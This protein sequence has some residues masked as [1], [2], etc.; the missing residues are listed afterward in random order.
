MSKG[1]CLLSYV[2]MR[3]EP[4]SGAE[5]VS[6]LIFGES[7]LLT[8]EDNGFVKITT[9]FDNYEGWISKN[10]VSEYIPFDKINDELFVIAK[11]GNEK[12]FIPCGANMPSNNEFKKDEIIFKIEPS[13]RT[14]HHLPIKLRLTKTAQMFLNTP[15]I[16]GGRS[17]MGIDCSGF[18][19]IVFKANGINLLRDTNQQILQGTEVLF[20][21]RNV[22]DLVF[23]SKPN[24]DKVTHAGLL[25]NSDTVIHAS[26]FVK[27]QALEPEGLINE[28]CETEYK[29]MAI[30]RLID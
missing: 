14:N 26:G 29:L 13:V 8:S 5:M 28:N 3:S 15:Y 21:N 6:S 17:F 9:D 30:K 22:G 1:T 2:P 12:I 24:S 25:Y 27:L 10:T 7:Y 16:W 19:Q 18:V 11:S 4:R 23:F 20:E